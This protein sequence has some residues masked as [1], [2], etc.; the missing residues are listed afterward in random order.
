MKRL[1]KGHTR[2]AVKRRRAPNRVWT[3]MVYMTPDA[4][5]DAFAMACMEQMLSAR[6]AKHFDLVVQLHP[7]DGG[8]PE[9]VLIKQD[10]SPESLRVSGAGF[11]S[12]DPDVLFGFL[13]EV[14]RQFPASHYMLVL[15]GHALGFNFGLS[16]NPTT[17]Q[18]LAQVLKKFSDLRGHPLEILGCDACRMSKLEIAAALQ[19]SVD[20]IVASQIGIPLT[21]WP[22]KQI[23]DAVSRKRDLSPRQLGRAVIDS[24]CARYEPRGVTLTML[25]LNRGSP[26]F[27]A[28][29]ALAVAIGAAM[30]DRR[31]LKHFFGAINETSRDDVEPMIGLQDFCRNL[32]ARTSNPLLRV[33]TAKVL[34]L[35]GSRSKFVA[36]HGKNGPGV[37]HFR[38]VG[39][40][41]PRV[42]YDPALRNK[43]VTALFK[44]KQ[45]QVNFETQW[46]QMIERLVAASFQEVSLVSSLGS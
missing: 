40:Y 18:E 34:R 41:V 27:K 20:L 45:Q 13:R 24:Y 30:S 6:S 28:V 32:R 21:S 46:S 19:G 2:Q 3:I 9:R 38:G 15:W 1:K 7:T 10:S 43:H 11:D 17:A 23:L 26:I 22:Y 4:S 25:D 44:W 16:S 12:G 35:L 29:E 5:L 33:S 8:R 14:S 39:I 36:K 42:V 31:E 37:S